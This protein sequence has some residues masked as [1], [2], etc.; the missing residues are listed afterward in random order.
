VPWSLAAAATVLL[1]VQ[2]ATQARV[3]STTVADSVE[4]AEIVTGKGELATVRLHDGSVV[5]LAP[6]S[7]LRMLRTRHERGVWVEGHVF[8]AVAKDPGRPF[9]VRTS[10]GDLVVLGT[11]FDVRTGPR[12]LRLAVLEGRVAVYAGGE[13]KEVA[14][15]EATEVRDGL[16]LPT[17]KLAN[18][19]DVTKWM[20]RFLAF[21]STDL[22]TVATEV[23]RVYGTRVVFADPSLERETVS[24]SFT[25]ESLEHVMR[26]IC[27]VVGVQCTVADSLVTIS[28]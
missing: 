13:R 25:D 28:R 22:Q 23:E 24:A 15:G 18:A 21:Q 19:D 16:T 5:R 6:Q 7:R 10:E 4:P 2:L 12:G 17:L 20:R 27:T 9:R 3:R 1:A 14:G 11:R 8:F 26:V